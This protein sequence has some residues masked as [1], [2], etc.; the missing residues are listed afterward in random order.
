MFTLLNNKIIV[1]TSTTQTELSNMTYQKKYATIELFNIKLDV[2]YH[3]N[4]ADGYIQLE[5]IEDVTGTQDLM[6]IMA[7]SLFD[8]VIE[9]IKKV[10][11]V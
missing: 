2:T 8:N 5:T 10:E 7:Q 4:D 3:I 11:K 1:I 6:P 9:L